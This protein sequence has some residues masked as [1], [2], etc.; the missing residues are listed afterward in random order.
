MKHTV[1]HRTEHWSQGV[2]NQRPGVSQGSASNGWQVDLGDPRQPFQ[3]WVG[4]WLPEINFLWED[5]ELL[6][7]YQVRYGAREKVDSWIQGAIRA[8]AESRR[9]PV[10]VSPDKMLGSLQHHP[11]P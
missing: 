1:L 3:F 4:L 6:T 2:S 11:R 7:C 5:T 10:P 9:L 8:N